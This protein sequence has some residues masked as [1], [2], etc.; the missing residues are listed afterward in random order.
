MDNEKN[1]YPCIQV[2]MYLRY[3]WYPSIHLSNYPKKIS[4]QDI[5]VSGYQKKV[6][7]VHPYVWTMPSSA[8]SKDFKS[9]IPFFNS[10]SKRDQVRCQFS[11]IHDILFSFSSQTNILIVLTWTG[12][13][14]TVPLWYS[15]TYLAPILYLNL[16]SSKLR[17]WSTCC[18]AS[19]P[20]R[21]FT[22]NWKIT[23]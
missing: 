6:V 11:R 12:L 8:L 9:S 7:S 18:T 14:V 16:N 10:F 23:V 17:A 13:C 15:S 21:P 1:W 19:W 5:Q 3:P 4:I 20:R 22:V 2:S